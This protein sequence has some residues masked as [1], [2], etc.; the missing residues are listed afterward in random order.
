MYDWYSDEPKRIF[1][2]PHRWVVGGR[3]EA[4]GGAPDSSPWKWGVGRHTDRR[5]AIPRGP[6]ASSV[7]RFPHLCH[8]DKDG[9]ATWFWPDLVT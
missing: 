7:P 1:L 5:A 2:E 8:R 6:W 4:Q 9:S 3:R